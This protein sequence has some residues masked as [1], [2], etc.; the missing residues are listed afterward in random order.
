MREKPF[1]VM[2]LCILEIGHKGTKMY[3]FTQT[4][5]MSTYVWQNAPKKN[6]EENGEKC[7]VCTRP[8]SFKFKYLRESKP[9]P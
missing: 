5:K 7:P 3:N 4:P 8:K 6:K 2:K 9:Y 1:K